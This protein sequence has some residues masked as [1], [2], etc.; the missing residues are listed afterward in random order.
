MKNYTIREWTGVFK[1]SVIVMDNVSELV[2]IKRGLE[3][4]IESSSESL[5]FYRG[6]LKRDD[7]TEDDKLR[8]EKNIKEYEYQLKM[9]KDMIMNLDN[10]KEIPTERYT[11]KKEKISYAFD[12]DIS[13]LSDEEILKRLNGIFP[14]KKL[15]LVPSFRSRL[16]KRVT[17]LGH[18]GNVV[19]TYTNN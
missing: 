15:Y 11:I 4:V 12:Y 8:Y 14:D 18:N 9:L 19:V 13:E 10:R 2:A 5:E 6:L 16:S 1:E 7:E 17:I 3:F